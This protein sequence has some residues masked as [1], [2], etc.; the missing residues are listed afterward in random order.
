MFS[1]TIPSRTEKL[2]NDILR[3]PLFIS[4][5]T[6]RKYNYLYAVSIFSLFDLFIYLSIYL[7]IYLSIYISIYLSMYLS[8]YLYIYLSI[9]LYIYLS[10]SLVSR[11]LV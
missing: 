1:A 11:V 2:A 6:V 9:Y 10:H 7:F 4:V 8:I 3:N 5:G